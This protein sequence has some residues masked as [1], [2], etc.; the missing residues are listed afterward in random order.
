MLQM[1]CTSTATPPISGVQENTMPTLVETSAPT[2]KTPM[3]QAA[4][5]MEL[6]LSL[7]VVTSLVPCS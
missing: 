1:F 5:V 6:S 7:I 2:M 3:T 4:S